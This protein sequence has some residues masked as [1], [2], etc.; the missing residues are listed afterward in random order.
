[1]TAGYWMMLIR[2][3]S[4]LDNKN[5]PAIARAMIFNTIRFTASSPFEWCG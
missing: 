4:K 1:M 5:N 2:T 3:S